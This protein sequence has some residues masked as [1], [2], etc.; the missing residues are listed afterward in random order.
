MTY[1]DSACNFRPVEPFCFDDTKSKVSVIVVQSCQE[2]V[3][4][5]FICICIRLYN[6]KQIAMLRSSSVL[7][8]NYHGCIAAVLLIAGAL[9]N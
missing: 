9:Q 5:D 1:Y 6:S 7:R 3:H 8:D 2:S 4:T